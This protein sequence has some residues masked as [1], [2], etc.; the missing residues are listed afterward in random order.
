MH[1]RLRNRTIVSRNIVNSTSKT[2]NAVKETTKQ[3]VTKPQFSKPPLQKS[4]SNH[5]FNGKRAIKTRKNSDIKI[6]KA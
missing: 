6:K 3:L 5:I 1:Y 2:A 4:L